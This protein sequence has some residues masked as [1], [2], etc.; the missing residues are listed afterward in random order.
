MKRH[1]A[2]A[3]K[4]ATFTLRA[5]G[6]TFGPFIGWNDQ[7]G[8]ELGLAP[9][10]PLELE[11]NLGVGL[12]DIDLTGLTVDDLKVNLGVG[13]TVVTLPEEGRFYAKIEGAI[14][15]TVVVIPV[16]LAARIRVDTGLA[17]SDLPDSYQQRGDVYTSP[18]Y[19]SADDRVDLEVSQ[20]I[21]RVAIRQSGT[22]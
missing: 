6:G 11:V 3:G 2:I 4:T 18:G 14:G 7:R 10:V 19:A 22:R 1:F 13:R 12:A 5:E 15:E 20:A 8:W 17:A 21:G 16:G 9:E